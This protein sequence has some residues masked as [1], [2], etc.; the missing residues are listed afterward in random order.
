MCSQTEPPSQLNHLFLI[1]IIIIIILDNVH[2][3]GKATIIIQSS[4]VHIGQQSCRETP[5]LSI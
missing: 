5:N 1:I 4:I 2:H 3:Y